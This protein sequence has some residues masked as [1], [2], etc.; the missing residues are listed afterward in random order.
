VSGHSIEGTRE[1]VLEDILVRNEVVRRHDRDCGIGVPAEKIQ[2]GQ[3]DS[4]GGS[5]TLGLDQNVV[6]RIGP[7]GRNPP[8]AMVVGDN[9][10]DAVPPRQ[11]LGAVERQG[12]E[13]P[14]ASQAAELL[15][16]LH[17]AIVEGQA[18]KSRAFA[19]R[20][21]DDPAIPGSRHWF[22]PTHA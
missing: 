12:Q 1:G 15:R 16:S 4:G 3:Q 19:A 2:E 5:T 10:Q 21:Y 20:Q 22:L 17:A 7:Q 13:R 9:D 18:P 11:A 8:L 6:A 14:V